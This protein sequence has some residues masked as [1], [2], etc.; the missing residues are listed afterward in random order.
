MRPHHFFIL[1]L[2]STLIAAGITLADDE[3]PPPQAPPK[4]HHHDKERVSPQAA[5]PPTLPLRGAA[6]GGS[7]STQGRA[8]AAP[9]RGLSMQHLETSKKRSDRA[10]VGAPKGLGRS[11]SL[12]DRPDR[13]T[14]TAPRLS[15]DLSP[16]RWIPEKREEAK[17]PVAIPPTWVIFKERSMAV[18]PKPL[19]AQWVSFKARG[20]ASPPAWPTRGCSP[21]SSRWSTRTSYVVTVNRS[22]RDMRIVEN[23]CGTGGPITTPNQTCPPSGSNG[24]P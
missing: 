8:T 14:A 16:E 23:G 22:C 11:S 10:Q 9:P 17:A 5:P 7:K 3:V 15:V 2:C 13:S 12:L 20:M 6:R 21:C 1:G 24:C 19:P 4:P 18:A